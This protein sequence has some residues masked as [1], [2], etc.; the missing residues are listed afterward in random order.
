MS[1]KDN[2]KVII[3]STTWC[4]FCHTEAQWLDH[5]GVPYEIRNIE[6]N[7]DFQKELLEKLNGNFSGVPVSDIGGK[8]IL[9]FDRPKLMDAMKSFGLEPKMA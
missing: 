7:Q 2:K 3:Y 4:A 8:M 9:G 1:D 6:E 5:L